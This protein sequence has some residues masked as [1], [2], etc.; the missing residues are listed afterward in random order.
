MKLPSMNRQR[1]L[2]L[3]RRFCTGGFVLVLIALACCGSVAWAGAP[4]PPVIDGKG[5]DLIDFG[6]AIC[7]TCSNTGRPG[8]PEGNCTVDTVDATRD[9]A[10]GDPNADPCAQVFTNP[11][12]STYFVNGKD[13]NRFVFIYDRPNNNIYILWRAEGMIGDLDGN[14]D[15]DNNACPSTIDPDEHTNIPDQE[16]IL[17]SDV[18]R[19][20][21]DLDCDGFW[22]H[23]EPS[24]QV[25]NNSLEVIHDPSG[26][27]IDIG[28]I[29]P[30]S[31][32]AYRAEFY[33][34]RPGGGVP[35]ATG[36]DLEA[37]V[38]LTGPGLPAV[39][40]VRAFSGSE[41]DFLG[42]DVTRFEGC[43][44]F[45]GLA[46][47]KTASPARL[48][49]NATTTVTLTVH[50]TSKVP[51]TNVNVV[52][53]LPPGLSYV[54]GSTGS[55]CG[56]GQPTVTGQHVAWPS[57][58]LAV[59]Q[60]CAITFQARRGS[61]CLGRVTNVAGAS[62]SFQS[63]CFNNV[64]MPVQAPPASFDLVCVDAPAVTLGMVCSPD[65][66]CRGGP[67]VLTA[68]A[69]NTSRSPEDITIILPCGPQTFPNVSPNDQVT[70]RCT[71]TLT[72]CPTQTFSGS[73]T[74]HNECGDS[75]PAATA[76][77]A[78]NCVPQPAVS[79]TLS[80]SPARQCEGGPVTVT[81]TATNTSDGTEDITITVAGTTQKFPGVP[82]HESRTLTVNTTLAQCPTQTFS[83]SA[84][85]HNECG[86]SNPPA[87]GSC[88]VACLQPAIQ[89]VK[90][91]TGDVVAG[92]TI[93]YTLTVRNPSTE[94]DLDRVQLTDDLCSNS[95]NPRNFTSSG[96]CA[97]A[98]TI[99]GS[100]IVW[101]DFGLGRGGTCVVEF[102]ATLVACADC[103]NHTGV[104][105][106][107]ADA[108]ADATDQAFTG[109]T[110]CLCT[111]GYP[112]DSSPPRS[113]V[114]FNESEV[115][116]YFDP[117]ADNC[118]AGQDTIKL[119]YSDEHAL[120]LG[121]SK[122][123]V[124]GVEHPFP[125]T[126]RPTAPTCK[127][128]AELQF[129]AT[130]PTGDLSG[131][132]TAKG[133]GRPL[134]PAL[135]IT[136]LTC[137]GPKSRAGDWQQGGVGIPPQR[138]CGV[139]KGAIKT[140]DHSRVPSVTV[141][142]EADPPKNGWTLGGG[143]PPKV[144]FNNLTNQGYGAECEWFVKDL[145]LVAGHTYRLYFM[146][147]DGDQN[148]VGGD[149]GHACTTVRISGSTSCQVSIA[150]VEPLCVDGAP[151]TLVGSPPGGTFSGPG[152]T[153]NQ[154]NPAAA[155]VGTWTVSYSYTD[156]VSGC[157]GANTEITVRQCETSACSAASTIKADFNK[158][159][160]TGTPADP[161]YI[162]FNSN[163]KI[164]KGTVVAGTQI[165]LQ[166][167]EV[168]INEQVYDVPNANITFQSGSCASTSYDPVTETWNTTVPLAGSDEIFLSGLA[169]PIVSLK[170]DAKASWEGTFQTNTPGLCVN[171][172]WGAAVYSSFT[173]INDD[174]YTID[175]NAATIKAAH[176]G[177]CGINNS[178]H[179]GT[180][181]NAG[182]R[183]SL[184][185][186]ARG[187]GGTN[188]TGSLS[189]GVKVCP[190]CP[191]V[192]LQSQLREPPSI[193]AAAPGGDLDGARALEPYPNPFQDATHVQYVVAGT[194]QQQ[195]EIG[196]YDVAGRR[197]RS[198]VRGALEPGRYETFW[199]GADDRGVRMAK[200]MYF[201]RVMIGNQVA[202]RRVLYLNQ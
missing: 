189:G 86:D 75:N 125:I 115:L 13:L 109:C 132:D 62:A 69:T 159:A 138:V 186:G 81:G 72:Q 195:V 95:S 127:Q 35:G 160:I 2:A 99:S 30:S 97:R 116:R 40:K 137:Y 16:G 84:F 37:V 185:K 157:C 51:L 83:G 181:Q 91:A 169:V 201:V 117:G 110:Q 175:Y 200:G 123:I 53:D 17:G 100:H 29:G 197:L 23:G 114:L 172:K 144:G 173:V 15:P 104:S 67:V 20:D 166:N 94:V 21:F 45:L 171:W 9:I 27:P 165:R 130:D 152:V 24:I 151:V 25:R 194:A 98:P 187:D 76:S 7:P 3:K 79:L 126:P 153:G 102:D 107:C 164:E 140:V 63:L 188:F 167:A 147:H 22:N 191:V 108:R 150:P 129:G 135:F 101:P 184:Q 136:D 148:K 18:Y 12:G 111:V 124:D 46:L 149:V 113:Q 58:S 38:H 182:I 143:E 26:T 1:T 139:W 56:V 199:D 10:I 28:G 198:L 32:F 36:K 55:T 146:V 61:E 4:T 89:V 134:W 170:G 118:A 202:T 90:T 39:Y 8:S 142:P 131:N 70:A 54:S 193:D 88:S 77:C 60:T 33:G 168:M 6:A 103:V 34:T 179:A 145:G 133:G 43:P 59:D 121:V 73:A 65:R 92:G 183:A 49:P 31:A 82:A 64:V 68:T 156:P 180:P 42:E 11:N 196:V 163:F 177:A 48:C 85:G 192:A 5:Q 176:N 112:D 93:H 106:F 128:G 162:W 47:D 80:C 74:G 122:V 154:F 19:A 87:T 50:N 52:D 174:P 14:G 66:Q 120:T 119:W 155:G 178:D 158:S 190:V 161:T 141:T 57:F 71:T 96:G 41:D 78:V 44:P 105:G